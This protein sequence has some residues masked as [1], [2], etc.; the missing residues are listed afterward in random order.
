MASETR[1]L[2]APEKTTGHAMFSGDIR[3]P[4]MLIGKILRSPVPHARIKKIGKDRALAL[5][6]VYAVIT[7]E[8][9]PDVKTGQAVQDEVVMP[10]DK[11][12]YIGE[13][14]AAVAAVDEE[15]ARQALALIELDLE[16]LPGVFSFEQSVA[17][18]AP[19][20]HEDFAAYKTT[21]P[22]KRGGNV[23]MHATIN[24]GDV[25]QGFAQSDRI[26]EDTYTVPVV[27]HAPL[28]PRAVVAEVDHTGRLHVLCGTAR[29]FEI[30]A[31]VALNVGLPMSHIRVT[32]TRVGGSFG[33]KGSSSIEPI[34]ALLALK[35]R[36][37]VKMELTRKEDFIGSTPRHSMEIT[38]KTGVKNDGTLLARKALIKVD[39]GAYAYFG[40]KATSNV[41]QMISGP[42][43]IPNLFIEGICAYTN[44]MSCGP[45]RGP[46]APQAH[47]AAE[48]QLERIARELKIDSFEIRL[49]NA[50]KPNDTTATGQVLTDCDYRKILVQLRESVHTHF[51]DLTATDPEKA[52]GIGIS[53]G[54]WGIPGFGSSATLRFN[55][56]GSAILLIGSVEIG[57]G[58]DTA[59]AL[60]VSR[61]LG[62]ALERI[63]VISGDTDMCP[64]DYGAIGSR[65]TQA[66]GVAV[67]KA[68]DGVKN[69]LLDFAE[70]HL[71]A[72]RDILAFDK[73]RIHVRENEKV[74]IPITMAINL[75]TMK[76]G[77]PVV[78]T[79]SNT[80]PSPPADPRL[81][82]SMV[83]ASSPFHAFGAHAV[84][85]EVD[86]V[87]GKVDVLK[88][89]AVHD[90]GKAVF[91]EGI[92]GQI[93]GGVAMG[94]GYALSEE[95]V[96][97]DGRPLNDS[98]LDYRLPTMQ[99]V[100]RIIPVILE[101]ENPRSPEDILGVGEPTT[102]PTAAAVANAVYNAVNAQ[103][104]QLPMTPERVY[105][106]LPENVL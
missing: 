106:Q 8:D 73:G 101:K 44:K 43:Y 7:A 84:A 74:G 1:R 58:S 95:V 87:T 103:I 48:T 31:G 42:Y 64:F 59:M 29:A 36:K 14:V 11:V 88:V 69:Q 17:A 66:M 90:V 40:P 54:F 39:T 82:D 83:G 26:F 94:L 86:R 19:L 22:L 78:A 75:L 76:K 100:P 23:C 52:F 89:I 4:G 60:L 12:R 33:Q 93:Q 13:P 20:V 65:T 92:E 5:P 18:G 9:F 55:Q 30:R 56:D 16:E 81:F 49:K 102:I 35:T 28:E 80:T 2:E 45:C 50:F 77:G 34:A 68:I 3:R 51:K 104:R 105:W 21:M 38:I 63:R 91:R 6:G 96:F 97:S 85:V 27:H 70:N 62:I 25:E 98:F 71:E 10:R 57:T 24:K 61:E 15:T 32:G 47:F 53:G 37:P 67:H 79:G 99:D 72:P 41:A 46:G